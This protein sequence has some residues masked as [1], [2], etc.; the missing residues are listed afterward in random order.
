MPE[1]RTVGV[2]DLKNQ[3]S[4]HLRDVKAGV[5]LLV[6]ERN[7]VIAELRPPAAYSAA[8]QPVSQLDDWVNS[9][10][11]SPPKAPRRPMPSSPVDLPAGT[12]QRL[13]DELRAE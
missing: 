5:C 9:G 8:H 10:R 1:A 12:A 7:R 4:A 6:T 11:L 13:L 3:L 2:R